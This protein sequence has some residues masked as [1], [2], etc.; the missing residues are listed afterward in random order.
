MKIILSL[1]LLFN[2][3]LLLAQTQVIKGKIVDADAQYPLIGA[4]IMV[5]DTDPAIGTVT[6]LEGNYRLDKV[7][8]GRHNLR[9]L[10]VGYKSLQLPNVLVTAG[11][12]VILNISLEESVETLKDIVIT[13][14]SSK[15]MPLNELA[16]VSA[17]TFSLE[18]VTRFSGGRNDVARLATSFA[19][20]SAPDDSRNDIVVRGNSPSGLLW[21]IE[22][23]PMATTN[24]FATYGTTGGPV[25]ALNTNMLRTSDFLS[26]AF[27]AEY[28]NANAA[29]F[30]INF[31][32]GNPDKLEFTG[33][34]GAFTGLEFMA[35]GPFQK[36]NDGSFVASYRYGIASLAATGTSAT[37]YYQDLSFKVNFGNTAL[38]KFEMFGLGGLS[39]ID[40]YGDEIDE[41]DLFAN[42][43]LD[44]FVK[45]EL[46]L[47]GLSHT[48]NLSKNT[49]LK[50]SIGA[51]TNFNDYLQNNMVRNIEGKKI[52]EFLGAYSSDRENRYTITSNLNKKFNA[53]WKLRAGILHETYQIIS[54]W[55]Q[56]DNYPELD[57][58][59]DGIP[60]DFITV[61]DVDE[62]YNL[63]QAYAQIENNITDDLSLTFGLHS[64]YQALNE[65]RAIEP[66]AAI[67]WSFSPSQRLSFAYGLHAQAAPGPILFYNEQLG[68]GSYERTN[69]SLDF[70]Q[71]HHYVLG[72]DLNIGNDWRLKT[73]AYYQSLFD[74]PVESTPSSYSVINQGA[75]FI[76]SERG[77]LVNEGTG[78]NYG[79]ELTLEKFFSRGYYVLLTS[80]V[81]ESTYEGSDG[82]TRNT[83]FNTNY[84]VN[85]LMGKEWSFGKNG[86]NAWTLDTKF[87]NAGARPYTP[88]D[89]QGSRANGGRQVLFDER[90]FS[91]FYDPYLRWDVKLGVRL[92]STKSRISHQFFIDLQ[93]VLNYENEFVRRYNPVT[94]DINLVKQIGFFP[95]VM[96]RI[97]F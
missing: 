97:Q 10:Y 66:R 48:V 12:E 67:S 40:F 60:D 80:S 15:D 9:V 77:S 38:G 61:R 57:I 65:S 70:M 1:A 33:Q 51:S 26:G 23:I 62:I 16:K 20:V 4:T 30:D 50:T 58:D 90:A 78:T 75:D 64:Q 71:S 73:E 6:D 84:V 81:F 27:P 88:I 2:F 49:F 19:G 3:T 42:P 43:E 52:D 41:N 7:P 59:G 8:L 79:M 89:L 85:L 45:N 82:I 36:S 56:A 31:R 47:I 54:I 68:D 92:N 32:N 18:E 93:N 17:R 76:F 5:E 83:A 11:K 29:V 95:D 39:S 72:Y 44:A 34:L 14:E 46:G 86:Q 24:H 55:R 25:N 22:G 53:R 35:E 94:D 37:P 69:L 96:Y 21:R 63:S 13:G 91:E 74:V 87:T 28:G